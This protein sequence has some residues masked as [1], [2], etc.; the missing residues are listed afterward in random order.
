M[1][2][3]YQP[4]LYR[5]ALKNG[6]SASF[7]VIYKETDLWVSVP[8]QHGEER[9]KNYI[10]GRVVDL[11]KQM[12]GYIRIDPGFLAAL[13][14]YPVPEDAPAI[15]KACSLAGELAGVGPMAAVA[16]AFSQAVAE[17]AVS[18]FGVNEIIVENGGDIYAYFRKPL[19]LSVYAGGSPLSGRI[20]F[21][22]DP[23]LS[24]IGICTSSGT[25]GHS[26][27]F[28]KA[29]AVTVLS[30]N[31]TVADAFATMLCNRV[32]STADI[33]PVLELSAAYEALSGTIIVLGDRVGAR[34]NIKLIPL[35]ASAAKS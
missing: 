8:E 3:A 27:S 12:D 16:G 33:A 23:S 20:G 10:Y 18:E 9:L 15:V 25:V 28:G 6:I 30:T 14:P 31:A 7:T 26:L 21:E 24:P 19:A 13:E 29:D 32:K 2:K 5:S 22:I 17:D 1:N 4:R 34:G 11:R 35:A